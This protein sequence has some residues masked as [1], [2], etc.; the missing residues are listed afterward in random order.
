[1]HAKNLP[2]F[3]EGPLERKAL[4]KPLFSNGIYFFP[5]LCPKKKPGGK[6]GVGFVS[7]SVVRF[8]EL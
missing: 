5:H 7:P 8:F 3:V 1:M 2:P 6:G 4:K